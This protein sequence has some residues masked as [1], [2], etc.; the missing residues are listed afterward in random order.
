VRWNVQ[1]AFRIL[2]PAKSSSRTSMMSRVFE[3]L[4]TACGELI[5]ALLL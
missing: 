5:D 2:P 1:K 3:E 4:E